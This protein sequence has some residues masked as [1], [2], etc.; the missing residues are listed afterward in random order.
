MS[1]KTKKQAILF[2]AALGLAVASV[3]KPAHA[4]PVPP[5]HSERLGMTPSET[6]EYAERVKAY[7]LVQSENF[8]A[9]FASKSAELER[10]A[11]ELRE[12]YALNSSVTLA[13]KA[14]LDRAKQLELALYQSVVLAA[15]TDPEIAAFLSE[16]SDGVDALFADPNPDIQLNL[17]R[18]FQG[19]YG[20]LAVLQ[21]L[22]LA[23][24]RAIEAANN[25]AHQAVLAQERMR[26]QR[27]KNL[28]EARAGAQ[29]R[30][31]ARQY[32]NAR[33]QGKATT[34]DA[35]AAWLVAAQTNPDEFFQW[36]NVANLADDLELEEEFALAVS[37]AER[38]AEN[39]FEIAAL[40]GIYASRMMLHIGDPD[41]REKTNNAND[42]A[43]EIISG[44]Y[45][46]L[47][48]NRGIFLLLADQYVSN[49]LEEIGDY[50]ISQ[51]FSRNNID[52]TDKIIRLIDDL[53][54]LL[55]DGQKNIQDPYV[56]SY[57]KFQISR[58]EEFR[59]EIL[60][61]DSLAKEYSRNS[62]IQ[63]R[64]LL[65]LKPG[66]VLSL[67]FI[68][69]SAERTA[70]YSGGD[71]ERLAL[72][73]E[74]ARVAE[75]LYQLDPSRRVF[76]LRVWYSN[77]GRGLFA[78]SIGNYQVAKEAFQRTLIIG[79][80]IEASRGYDWPVDLA[81]PRL[82]FTHLVLGETAEAQETLLE[83][84]QREEA[85]APEGSSPNNGEAY[86]T[87][88]SA[89]ARIAIADI[90]WITGRRDAALQTY[91]LILDQL[92]EHP[93]LNKEYSDE[94]ALWR[95]LLPFHIGWRKLMAG[96]HEEAIT[97]F[98]KAQGMAEEEITLELDFDDS[99]RKSGAAMLDVWS[100]AIL[101]DLNRPGSGWELVEKRAQDYLGRPGL[102]EHGSHGLAVLA[103]VAS[104]RSRG[105]NDDGTVYSRLKGT[106]AAAMNSLIQSGL[107]L[108]Q[109]NEPAPIGAIVVPGSYLFYLS[110]IEEADV[111]LADAVLFYSQLAR[112]DFSYQLQYGQLLLARRT[113]STNE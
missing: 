100:T 99:E 76:K 94:L 85:R 102:N 51:S 32:S 33:S 72:Y 35:L 45:K 62:L 6:R 54:S 7:T 90:T 113:S 59:A 97:W 27:T 92:S 107:P 17:S 110:Q 81:L 25:A 9:R 67:S 56:D 4:Q 47:G 65:S 70:R 55:S 18:F 38:L 34:K 28:S 14:N 87:E 77:S 46:R 98:E 73:D 49:I 48:P 36:V 58:F 88:A 63:A 53:K 3:T 13:S 83:I 44:Q 39:E 42:K 103:D 106:S 111:P 15:K 19:D 104:R 21:A 105:T 37:Q 11:L 10:L 95:F 75:M 12:A 29:L 71:S 52:D 93:S 101:A 60:G 96:Q 26:Y 74:A 8:A 5:S 66:D 69:L 23:E 64:S 41:A 43:L 1:R 24:Y 86:L 84:V 50:R 30:F 79:K 82:S 40:Q 109:N 2:S 91:L 78:A 57:Y 68:S 89:H 80:E 112:R 22:V 61:N 16:V 31:I 108:V 20:A